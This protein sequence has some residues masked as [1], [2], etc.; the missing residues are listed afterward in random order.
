[1]TSMKITKQRLKLSRETVRRIGWVATADNPNSPRREDDTRLN[2]P[3]ADTNCGAQSQTC[4]D[5]PDPLVDPP[6]A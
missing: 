6:R 4:R 1:M 3:S 5:C 2:C